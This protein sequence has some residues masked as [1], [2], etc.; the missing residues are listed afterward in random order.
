MCGALDICPSLLVSATVMEMFAY[1]VL[2]GII[3]FIVFRADD[4]ME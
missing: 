4:R 1:D 3:A 2:D